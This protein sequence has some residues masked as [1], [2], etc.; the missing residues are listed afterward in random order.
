M[1]MTAPVRDF[2]VAIGKYLAALSMVVVM[3]LLTLELPALLFI[4]GSPDR[5]PLLTGYLGLFLQAAAFLAI[6]LLASSLTQNQI[7]AA[8]VTFV[9]LLV[10]WLADVLG[11]TL[12]GVGG[13]VVRA[14]AVGPHLQDLPSGIL[15]TRDV[16][17]FL[18]LACAGV[19]LTMIS[20]QVR[21]WR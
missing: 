2:E 21:R 5:G 19:F 15:D 16:V 11:D 3:I 6:G 12:N 20:L 7:V 4:Y 8:I 10:L 14:L 9:V 13:S 1:L 17:Y 18:S